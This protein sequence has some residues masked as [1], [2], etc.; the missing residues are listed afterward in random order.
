MHTV[1]RITFSLALA[2]LSLQPPLLAQN[3]QARPGMF[4]D[5][6]GEIVGKAIVLHGR[7]LFIDNYLIES[8]SGAKKVLN[9]PVKHP[10]N[11]LVR[12]DKP[13]EERLSSP[14]GYGAVVRDDRA[15]SLT[16]RTAFT[17][18]PNRRTL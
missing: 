16:R 2:I 5:L 15:A 6:D 17:G 18:S 8:L 13:W 10:Q 9:Q 4:K 1:V 14:F 3:R 7:Q 12:R 11:P